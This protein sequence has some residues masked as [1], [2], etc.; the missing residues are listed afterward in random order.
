MSHNSYLRDFIAQVSQIVFLTYL[1]VI[2]S[3]T[4]VLPK[5]SEISFFRDSSAQVSQIVFLA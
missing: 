5:I 4:T 2:R 3:I 1:T